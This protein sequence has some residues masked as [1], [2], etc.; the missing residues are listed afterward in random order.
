MVCVI[1]ILRGCGFC[2]V[3][4]LQFALYHFPSFG[5]WRCGK[6]EKGKKRNLKVVVGVCNA[7]RYCSLWEARVLSYYIITCLNWPLECLE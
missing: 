7:V 1:Y 3:V 5:Y 4:R 6:A 2:E